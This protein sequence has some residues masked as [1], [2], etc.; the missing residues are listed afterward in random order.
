MILCSTAIICVCF[1]FIKI[2]TKNVPNTKTIMFYLFKWLFRDIL[3]L[4]QT[5]FLKR[6]DKNGLKFLFC[7]C[8]YFCYFIYNYSTLLFATVASIIFLF[9]VQRCL[10]IFDGLSRS[11]R[12][13][14]FKKSSSFERIFW[15]NLDSP[16]SCT[17]QPSKQ[18]NDRCD[19]WRRN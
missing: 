19:G 18:K 13:R 1:K 6:Y 10:R 9:Q 14:F 12:K 2:Y 3:S 15:K 16:K 11:S 5:F 17:I 8:V 4:I 7:H